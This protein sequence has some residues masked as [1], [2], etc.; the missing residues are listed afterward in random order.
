MNVILTAMV[1]GALLSVPVTAAVWLAFRMGL[2]KAVNAATRYAILWGTLAVVM[3]LP[4]LYLPAR[5]VPHNGTSAVIP[6]SRMP[7]QPPRPAAPLAYSDAR[8]APQEAPPAHGHFPPLPVSLPTAKPSTQLRIEIGW[9]RWILDIWIAVAALLLT[10]L[11]VSWLLLE[12]ISGRALDAPDLQERGLR[13]MAAVGCRRRF[14]VAV[15]A[16]I[17]TPVAIGPL[18]ATILIPAALLEAMGEDELDQIGVHEAAHLARWDDYALLAQRA[19]EAVFALHPVVRWIARKIDLEREIACDDRVIASVG[20]PRSYATCLMRVVELSGDGRSLAAA[21]AADDRS[22]LARRIDMLLDGTRHTGTRLLKNRLALILATLAGLGWAVSRTPE[23]VAFAAPLVHAIRPAP[24]RQEAPR[25]LLLTP[26]AQSAAQGFEGRVLE[27]SSGNPLAS[28]ELRF[29]KAG[30]RELAAD[31]ETGRDGRVRVS[32]LDTGDYTVDV[33]KPNFVT[34][35][36]DVRL[37]NDSFLV[38]LVRF[39][40][41]TGEVG[42]TQGQPAP[43]RILDSG[44]T[45][46]STRICLLAK[47][48]GGGQMHLVADELPSPDGRYRIHDIPPGEYALALYYNGLPDGSG[49]QIY[50]SASQPRYFTFAGGEEYRDVNFTIAG[51]NSYRVSGQVTLPNGSDEYTLALASAD[52]PALPIA[53]T[54]TE[55]GGSF[56]FEKVPPG[57]YEMFV[58]GPTNGYGA[59]DSTIAKPPFYA[60]S[61]VQVDGRDVEGLQIAVA[62]GYSLSV[63]L[64]GQGAG[65]VPEGCSPSATVNAVLDE[66]W[67]VILSSSPIRAS[68]GKEA[69]APD[70]PPARFHVEASDLGANCYQ[71][72][73]PVA[74]LTGG[75]AKVAVE[76]A[77]AG[78]LHGVLKPLPAAAETYV[79]VLLE[80]DASATAQARLAAV[81]AQGRFALNGLRPGRY[82]LAAH[83]AA[84]ASKSRWVGDFGGMTEV[85][86]RGGSTTDIELPVAVEGAGVR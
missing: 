66:P 4:L 83:P 70:L 9:T 16:E 57:A 7:V 5:A 69:V 59:Y 19:V 15:S 1:N 77:A 44:R 75:A 86:I 64:R 82:R 47:S 79:V 34:A 20:R 8:P 61:R 54:V 84:A 46:G 65:G 26:Q 78:A 55:K 76:L 45:V 18:H 13:W 53:K 41:I 28:A 73:Q 11:A 12:R 56:H 6:P 68:A 52:Q 40:V 31:L 10:R 81:D 71:V 3:A 36:L 32:G 2:G 24:V 60:R 25:L 42:N 38:R 33:S 85:E 80:A 27:D 39:G 17:R 30:W 23:L 67:G 21:A 74:D 48:P 63:T 22:H 51:G 49:V 62:P 14:R 37:P 72:E 35:T 58:A 50:P 43:A 29:H